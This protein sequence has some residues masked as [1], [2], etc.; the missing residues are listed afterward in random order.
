MTNAKKKPASKIKT[1]AGGKLVGP[2]MFDRVKLRPEPHPITEIIAGSHLPS[3]DSEP[4]IE[5]EPLS[6]SEPFP[7]TGPPA[8]SIRGTPA[9]LP[10]LPLQTEPV[11]K[12]EPV[13][14]SEG[15]MF[16]PNNAPHLRFPYE[17]LD[18]ILPTLKPGA[19]VVCERLYRLSAGFD[20][21]ECVVSIGKLASSCNIGET[22]VRQYLR[23]L[24]AKGLIK[25]L[26]DDIANRNFEARGDKI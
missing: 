8:E 7:K 17:V 15:V 26:G 14:I 6:I 1:R 3:S 25:R 24:E 16:L 5:T 18:K 20:R 13:I 21:D 23:E 9:V 19:R 22:Q 10:A 4:I 11:T 2:G 12:S